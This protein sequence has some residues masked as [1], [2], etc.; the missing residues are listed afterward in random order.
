M[1]TGEVL[2]AWGFSRLSEEAVR[3]G[4][5]F[6]PWRIDQT[7]ALSIP[8]VSICSGVGRLLFLLRSPAL[9]SRLPNTS[10]VLAEEGLSLRPWMSLAQVC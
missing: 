2:R 9:A 4:L 7:P 5:A 10:D 1:W 8:V 3:G 6:S